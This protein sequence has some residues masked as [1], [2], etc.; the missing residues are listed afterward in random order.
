MVVN[1][2]GQE[3]EVLTPEAL[4][5]TPE[6]IL[7]DEDFT[8]EVNR[9]LGDVPFRFGVPRILRDVD[10]IRW[11][12][13]GED[14]AEVS[15]TDHTGIVQMKLPD[16]VESAIQYYSTR[17]LPMPEEIAKERDLAFQT[18]KDLSRTRVMRAVYAVHARLKEQYRS[19]KER[20]LGL[21][22]PSPT[23]Y[24]AAWVL[25]AEETRSYNDKKQLL[26]SFNELI[27]KTIVG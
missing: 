15:E 21:Y 27:Q 8:F 24:L 6:R 25:N 18:A 19:N 9:S 11:L 3:P 22:E 1:H 23:E 14:G 26:E 16:E 7:V 4:A 10:L 20:N 5:K 2:K 12:S 13:G 17:G